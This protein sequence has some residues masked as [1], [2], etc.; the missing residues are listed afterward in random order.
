MLFNVHIDLG[1]KKKLEA[2]FEEFHHLRS[3]FF[4][5]PA[6]YEV[7]YWSLVQG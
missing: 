3:C 7:G 6:L 2:C 1:F 5:I 4:L